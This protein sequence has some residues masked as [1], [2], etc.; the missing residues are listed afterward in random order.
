MSLFR[1]RRSVFQ[2]EIRRRPLGPVEPLRSP[3]QPIRAARPR[4]TADLPTIQ[5]PDERPLEPHATATTQPAPQ[6][7][8]ESRPVGARFSPESTGG[9]RRTAA[10]GE[11]A[12]EFSE[13]RRSAAA[14]RQLPA[15]ATDSGGS[16]AGNGAVGDELF[17]A[18]RGTRMERPACVEQ[19]VEAAG[20]D[21][22]DGRGVSCK[23]VCF[24]IS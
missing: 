9:I 22:V 23:F 11:Y 1:W 18:E 15:A 14:A 19:A 21:A 3:S 10:A 20:E 17:A 7:D 24:K 4:S 6:S 8:A 13:Q 16:H 12:T 2:N 5:L